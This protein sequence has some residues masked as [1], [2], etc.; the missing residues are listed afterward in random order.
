MIVVISP[1]SLFFGLYL[2]LYLQAPVP[3]VAWV[4]W[5]GN[6][7][8]E[9]Y[10]GWETEDI[11]NGI[12][13]YGS[14]PESLLDQVSEFQS[15]RVHIV[16]LTGL[17]AD[18]KYYYEVVIAGDIYARGEFRTAPDP[19]VAFS[20]VLTA[21]TQP[22]VGPGWI[23]RWVQKVAPK[24]YSFVAFVGD[25]VEEG[26]EAEWNFFFSEM[27]ALLDT[28]P[29][30]PVRG[31][32]DRPKDVNGDGSD[33]NFFSQYFP[34]TVDTVKDTNPYDTYPQF[35]YSFNWSSVHVQVLNFPEMDI[36][37][38]DAPNGVNPRD[39]FQ[40]FTADH[41]AWL[42]QDLANAQSMPFRITLFHCP[43]TSA[44][45]FGP[46]HVLVNQL[47]PTLLEYNVT[48]AAHGHAHHYERGV[49]TNETAWPGRSLT[50]FV[51]GTGGGLADLGLRPVPETKACAGS[52]CFTE[53]QATSSSLM[54]T[55]YSLDGDVIDTC[56][57]PAGGG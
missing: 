35:Y 34:Q 2:T 47:L 28:I 13:K 56:T 30:V 8:K 20:F 19:G 44:G 52:P 25:I 15:G 17:S 50:Y 4:S 45:F 57:I 27:G 31:N 21:D 9:V 36:D 37:D 29:I 54:V 39:Y 53:V 41:I 10:I 23:N 14:S 48:M 6:P 43:I 49:L 38:S 22:K 26:Y 40:A 18:T 1:L 7:Q 33:E 5:Y 55:A 51:V 46:N 12:V 16:N 42:K 11:T 3:H 32:H 24:N